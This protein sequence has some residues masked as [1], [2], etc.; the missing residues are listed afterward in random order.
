MDPVVWP[1][2]VL[3]LAAAI[4]VAEGSPPQWNNPGDLTY[5]FGFPV[6]G[7]M[8]RDG[9]LK[10]RRL[11]DGEHALRHECWLMLTGKSGVYFLSDSLAIAGMKYSKGDPNWA[12]NVAR[13][14]GVPTSTTLGMVSEMKWTT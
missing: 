10:F 13:E 6:L 1:Q 2:P 3:K 11:E 12:V 8:N 7:P 9:V 4:T 14:L 5:G